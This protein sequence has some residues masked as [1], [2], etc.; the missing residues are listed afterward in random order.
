MLTLAQSPARGL[1]AC[2]DIPAVSNCRSRVHGTVSAESAESA[3]C[4]PLTQCVG[5]D[6]HRQEKGATGSG[7]SFVESG[8]AG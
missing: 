1:S 8:A 5:S 3:L 4:I 2:F 6:K 7:Q